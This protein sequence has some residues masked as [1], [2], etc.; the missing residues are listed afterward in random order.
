VSSLGDLSDCHGRVPAHPEYPQLGQAGAELGGIARPPLGSN[1]GDA[2]HAAGPEHP[3]TLVEEGPPG[4]EME[5]RLHADDPVSRARGDRQP[6]RIAYY[7]RSSGR[8]KP[9]PAGREL[10]LD[11]VDRDQP[12]RSY[13][14][15]DHRILRA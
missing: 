15:C 1:V 11:N 9:I 7:R 12:M 14:L 13:D 10:P 8:S 3:V 2:Q 4:P 5:C 6:D